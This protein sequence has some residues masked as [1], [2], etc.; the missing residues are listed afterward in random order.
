MVDESEVVTNS[1][2]MGENEIRGPKLRYM[3]KAAFDESDAL[4][5]R[6]TEHQVIRGI[7]QW[8]LTMT[9]MPPCKILKTLNVDEESHLIEQCEKHY[10]K[11][12]ESPLRTWCSLRP[13]PAHRGR[14]DT[15]NRRKRGVIFNTS[16]LFRLGLARVQVP[17]KITRLRRPSQ[18]TTPEEKAVMEMREP[19]NSQV[20]LEIH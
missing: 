18:R 15:Q 20:R 1:H 9:F 4:A 10:K 16:Q 11:Y 8:K 6:Q 12:V 19:G 7:R 5:W 14:R 2:R 3:P 13:I 17:A